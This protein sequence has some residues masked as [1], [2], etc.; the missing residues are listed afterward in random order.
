MLTALSR[1]SATFTSTPP[2]AQT[3]RASDSDTDH[4]LQCGSPQQHDHVVHRLRRRLRHPTVR[5]DWLGNTEDQVA[6]CERQS[7]R[8]RIGQDLEHD[9]QGRT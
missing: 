2:F 6:K 8:H 7:L 5:R 1:C 3:R 9:Q 4:R